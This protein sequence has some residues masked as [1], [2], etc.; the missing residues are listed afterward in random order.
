[1][2]TRGAEFQV[3]AKNLG[4]KVFSVHTIQNITFGPP[5]PPR[6]PGGSNNGHNTFPQV[7]Y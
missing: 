3:F 6:G 2:T 7:Q 4:N 1:M 5:M